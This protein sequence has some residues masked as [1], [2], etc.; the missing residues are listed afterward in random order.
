LSTLRN[1]RWLSIKKAS[2]LTCDNQFHLNY[3]C[4]SENQ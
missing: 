1:Q 2:T 4:E 3:D